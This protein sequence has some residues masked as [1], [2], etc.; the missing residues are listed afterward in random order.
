MR[1]QVRALGSAAV[2]EPRHG[3]ENGRILD[4]H[5]PPRG[6]RGR[7]KVRA[8]ELWLGILAMVAAM[9]LVAVVFDRRRGR[10]TSSSLDVSTSGRADDQ[11]D[12]DVTRAMV[13]PT[14]AARTGEQPLGLGRVQVMERCAATASPAR[15]RSWLSVTTTVRCKPRRFLAQGLVAGCVAMATACAAGPQ[16]ADPGTEPAGVK[17]WVADFVDDAEA[18]EPV[19]ALD[20]DE[21]PVTLIG[22]RFQTRC[23]GA[24]APAVLLVSGADTPQTTWQE[25]QAKVGAK[26]RICS[27]DR[28]GVGESGPVPARQ[29]LE[30]LAA[31]LDGITEALE[32]SRPL[33]IVGHSLGGAIAMVWATTHPA[34]T[35]GVVL[36]DS[37]STTALREFDKQVQEHYPADVE[38]S[39]DPEHLDMSEG[40]AQLDSL[41]PLG[42]VPLVV[43]TSTLQQPDL[44]HPK[45]D[46]KAFE[47]AW[48]EGQH[49]WATY[50][51]QSEL[52]SV[53]NAGHV[54]QA[55][56]PDIVV[57]AVLRML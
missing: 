11:H 4:V 56:Q 29:T 40:S 13:R 23:V 22:R 36:I 6:W 12:G 21:R 28:L 41:S 18:I 30:E 10:A 24:G 48:I 54:I 15:R 20:N 1:Y 38:L 16:P 35:A 51:E 55:D 37:T 57:A 45:L 47:R 19:P 8:M 50:S 39:A 5:W 52:V 27:Y 3:A 31:D 7:W 33:V 42:T 2:P 17:S 34:D 32:L 9:A 53:P 14:A 26:T 43:L 46:G 49:H 44:N 25:V